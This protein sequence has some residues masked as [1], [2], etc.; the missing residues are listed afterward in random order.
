[1]HFGLEIYLVYL[2]DGARGYGYR[3]GANYAIAYAMW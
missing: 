1:M 3:E 2:S